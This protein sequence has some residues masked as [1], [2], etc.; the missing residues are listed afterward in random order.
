MKPDWNASRNPSGSFNDNTS[1]AT[2]KFG[3]RSRSFSFS[4]IARLATGLH[5]YTVTSAAER[6]TDV[7]QL[8]DK[9]YKSSHRNRS[10]SDS[11]SKSRSTRRFK[12]PKFRRRENSMMP[13][14]VKFGRERESYGCTLP[15]ETASLE[16]ISVYDT[17]SFT[18]SRRY[19]ISK[20]LYRQPLLVRIE[21]RK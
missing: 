21:M 2:N 5:K 19:I 9:E 4:G 14:K 7:E 1:Q 8:S 17:L 16:G 15:S 12:L 3:E 11:G 18:V 13:I 10:N 6:A 20:A